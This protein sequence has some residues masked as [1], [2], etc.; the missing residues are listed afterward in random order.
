M[1]HVSLHYFL[2]EAS[3]SPMNSRSLATRSRKCKSL[4]ANAI[5]SNFNSRSHQDKYPSYHT[6]SYDAKTGWD[7]RLWNNFKKPNK[8]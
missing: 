2:P 7:V 4:K 1:C 6:H 5:M 8:N 3:L